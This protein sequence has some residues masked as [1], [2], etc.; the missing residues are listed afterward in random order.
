MATVTIINTE[1]R[2]YRLPVPK[3][4]KRGGATTLGEY[5]LPGA[6]EVDESLLQKL[7]DQPGS[8]GD[9]VRE[10][11]ERGSL[12]FQEEKDQLPAN[13]M[14]AQE[15]VAYVRACKNVEELTRI[16][17]ND[18]RKTVQDAVTKRLEDLVKQD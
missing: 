1:A 9:A 15:A 8:A 4:D 2:G 14:G 16:S 5:L 17:L 13:K 6:N 11:F 7:I 12:K 10:Y 18:T 3:A